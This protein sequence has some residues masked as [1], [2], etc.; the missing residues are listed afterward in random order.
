MFSYVTIIMMLHIDNN[1]TDINIK[2]LSP[3]FQYC[4]AV[5][6]YDHWRAVNTQD[7]KY[8]HN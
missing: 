6:R 3:L 1:C 7:F 5:P 2:C 4:V 8:T